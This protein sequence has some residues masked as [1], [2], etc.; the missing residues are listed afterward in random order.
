MRVYAMRAA[1]TF[2]KRM[3]L[4]ALLNVPYEGSET[5]QR[6]VEVYLMETCKYGVNFLIITNGDDGAVG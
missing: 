1:Y 5:Q 3:I 6:V 4:N 2:E